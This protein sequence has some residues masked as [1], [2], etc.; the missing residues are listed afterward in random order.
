MI[1]THEQLLAACA[2]AGIDTHG[3]YNAIRG[4]ANWELVKHTAW[5]GVIGMRDEWNNT[6]GALLR[7]IEAAC[8]RLRHAGKYSI[9]GTAGRFDSPEEAVEFAYKANGVL[10]TRVLVHDEEYQFI[11]LHD[12]HDDFMTKHVSDGTSYSFSVAFDKRGGG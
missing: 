12:E 5:V 10:P 6:Q 7:E 2:Q 1:T 4:R 3:S 9:M 11:V 8:D